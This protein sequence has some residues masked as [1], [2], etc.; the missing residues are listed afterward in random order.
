MTGHMEKEGCCHGTDDFQ[1]RPEEL[2]RCYRVYQYT[3][4]GS[5]KVLIQ[6]VVIVLAVKIIFL[7]S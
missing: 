4:D 5:G 1:L 7:L 2:I 3:Q 6:V